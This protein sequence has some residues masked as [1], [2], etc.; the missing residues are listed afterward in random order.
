MGLFN[1]AWAQTIREP[2]LNRDLFFLKLF[3]RPQDIPPKIP[4]YPAKKFGFPGLR[5]TYRTFWP[6]PVHVEDPHPD[7]RTKKFGFGFLCLPEFCVM[8][9]L[10]PVP[11]HANLSPLQPLAPCHNRLRGP[12]L[13][14]VVIYERVLYQAL[15][16]RETLSTEGKSAVNLSN[17]GKF[18]QIWPRAIY[19]C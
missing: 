2:K 1:R 6:P 18:C 5:R 17:L 10:L 11:C 7:I 9:W 13:F 3:G 4:G 16:W 19:L 15:G 14:S 8:F 12:T